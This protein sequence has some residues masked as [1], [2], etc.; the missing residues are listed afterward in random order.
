[1]NKISRRQF[2]KKTIVMGTA[3]AA[4]PTVVSRESQAKNIA[5]VVVHPYVDN[6]R[7]VGITD[8]SMTKDHNP[9]SSWAIQDKLVISKA[10]WE[11]IDKLACGLAET[12]N[13]AEAW[14]T[15]FIKPPRRSWSDTVVAIKTNNIALQ[16]THSAVM[17]KICH[18]FTDILGVRPSNIRIYDACH[19]SSI[20]KN[21]PF[22]D[23][24]EGCRI[25]NRW[26]GSSVYTSVPEPWKKGTSESKCLKY[27]V[28]GSVGI[29]VNIAMCK[30]HSQR[31]GGFTMTMKNHFGTFSPSPGHE[32]G[33]QDYLIA[34]N[35]TPEILGEMDKQTGKI[36]F[37][38]QQLCLVDA[39]WASKGGP[40]GNPTHQPNFLA[41]GVLS[42]IVDYQVAT[43]FRGERMGWQP[44]MKTSHRM[45]TDFGYN[46]SDLPAGG[47]IIEL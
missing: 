3:F 20:S 11:N 34:I 21:T 44:N 12:G 9:A 35:R 29:L 28:D 23:L 37:P 46:E 41:M 6:L 39:L 18:T 30:G 31:F 32:R 16:H 2:M 36:L 7:V 8:I 17:A 25:E 5:K 10:V 4:F 42:P 33:G 15:I 45:L 40:G 26:G 14:R 13:L 19:G 24:P 22:S 27:L 47:K 1:M 43:K 38:R